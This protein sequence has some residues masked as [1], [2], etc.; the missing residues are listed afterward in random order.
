MKLLR[1]LWQNGGF[2]FRLRSPSGSVIRTSATETLSSPMKQLLQPIA[3]FV[4][5]NLPKP[6]ACAR[7]LQQSVHIVPAAVADA[8][9]TAVMTT[10]A[11]DVQ[12]A[13]FAPLQ[14]PVSCTCCEDIV[15]IGEGVGRGGFVGRETILSFAERGRAMDCG[16]GG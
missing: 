14:L 10:H 8:V 13:W 12:V 3:L 16:V 11:D 9:Q 1:T 2:T 4:T 6:S 15:G 5:A 7:D